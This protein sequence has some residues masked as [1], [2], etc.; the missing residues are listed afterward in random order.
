V[1]NWG[2]DSHLA[3]IDERLLEVSKG[4]HASSSHNVRV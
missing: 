1:Q 3:H 4:W 2:L